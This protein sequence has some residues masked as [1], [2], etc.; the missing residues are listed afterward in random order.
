MVSDCKITKEM[1][2]EEAMELCPR[3][4]EIFAS[5]GMGCAVCLISSAETVEEGASMH[6]VDVGAI[7]DELNACAREEQNK[8]QERQ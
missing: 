4:P 2:I 6:G 3:A 8:G 7:V 1:K 5:H